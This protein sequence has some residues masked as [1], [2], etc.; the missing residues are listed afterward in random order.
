[1]VSSRQGVLIAILVRVG[2]IT[3]DRWP[4]F[5]TVTDCA[6]GLQDFAICIEMFIAALAHI[7]AFS[8]KPYKRELMSNERWW[9]SL[10][11]AAN[12]SD[13]HS[14][15]IGHVR[16]IGSKVKSLSSSRSSIYVSENDL[17]NEKSRLLASSSKLKS[18]L[19]S[20][21]DDITIVKAESASQILEKVIVQSTNSNQDESS[22][23]NFYASTSTSTQN[24]SRIQN[25]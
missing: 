25:C 3:T 22:M 23:N 7:F 5:H 10:L 9:R 17:P 15:V 1:L 24:D 13:V 8:H 11:Q 14:D 18:I 2:I 19:V 16:H 21:S 20:D 6:N 12:V 4:Y